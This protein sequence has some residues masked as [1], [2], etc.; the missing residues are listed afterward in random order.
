MHEVAGGV[1]TKIRQPWPRHYRSDALLLAHVIIT[2]S[3]E[4]Y[5]IL[6]AVRPPR[7]DQAAVSRP[8]SKETEVSMTPAFGVPT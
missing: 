3:L 5:L 8:S 2:S 6:R 1:N 7:C 4:E